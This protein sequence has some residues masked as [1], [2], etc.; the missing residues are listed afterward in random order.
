ML[1][2]TEL[3]EDLLYLQER[4]EISSTM[5][6]G[7]TDSPISALIHIRQYKIKMLSICMLFTAMGGLFIAIALLRHNQWLGLLSSM[8]GSVIIVYAFSIFKKMKSAIFAIEKV[9][10]YHELL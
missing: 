9:A 10:K 6:C 3:G 1:E 2:T 5:V 8:M 7:L 4:Y